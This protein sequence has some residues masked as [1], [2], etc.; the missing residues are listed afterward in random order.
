MDLSGPGIDVK[1]KERKKDAATKGQ[2]QLQESRSLPAKCMERTR[3]ST[4]KKIA[5]GPTISNNIQTG[6]NRQ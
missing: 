6:K 3:T 2:E 5:E 4:P 1:L